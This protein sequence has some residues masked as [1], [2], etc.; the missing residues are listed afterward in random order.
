MYR[1]PKL[2]DLTMTMA[3]PGYSV[4]TSSVRERNASWMAF[5]WWADGGPLLD[6]YCGGGQSYIFEFLTPGTE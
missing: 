2:S 6:A 3:Q 1:C 4:G 5:R